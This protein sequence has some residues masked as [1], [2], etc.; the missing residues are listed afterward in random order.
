MNTND[1]GSKDPFIVTANS[2]NNIFE[3][4]D[5]SSDAKSE[6]TNDTMSDALAEAALKASKSHQ[7]LRALSTLRN[8]TAPRDSKLEKTVDLPREQ[9][10]GEVK[11]ISAEELATFAKASGTHAFLATTEKTKP[12]PWHRLFA[13]TIDWF[14]SAF[15]TC[16]PPFFVSIAYQMCNVPASISGVGVVVTYV[17]S[18]IA[19]ILYE[20]LM[21]SMWGT[22][23]GKAMFNI[24][25]RE[26]RTGE[27]LT[28]GRAFKRML[29][30]WWYSGQV[31]SLVPVVGVI[32]PIVGYIMQYKKLV[33]DKITSYDDRMKVRYE[34]G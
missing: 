32:A 19:A 18:I 23:L 22:T 31:L 9:R 25:V 21:L 34:H 17:F 5:G 10:L 16:V 14:V 3:I 24:K 12:H 6:V 13:R 11:P 33:E 29:W 8:N 26:Q 20:P 15:I 1:P 7:R 27:Y 30:M 4:E 28:F 2:G